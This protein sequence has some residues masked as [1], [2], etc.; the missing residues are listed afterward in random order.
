MPQYDI[1]SGIT[2]TISNGNTTFSISEVWMI[3]SI[4]LAIIGGIYLFTNY[5]NREKATTYTGY[6][7]KLYDFLHFEITIIEPIFKVLY[8]IIAISIT[9]SSFSFITQNFFKF[10]GIL[11]FGNLIARLTFELLLLTLKMFKDISEINIKINK[12]K[13]KKSKQE[14]E[15]NNKTD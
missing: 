4:L 14:I 10:I 8:L 6:K 7:K 11:V 12:D 15:D 13:T 5:F 9:L 3:I 1:D 2:N